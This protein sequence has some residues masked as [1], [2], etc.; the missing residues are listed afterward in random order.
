MIND[1]QEYKVLYNVACITDVS[2]SSK[3]LAQATRL[4]L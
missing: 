1:L 4:P 3:K 2:K